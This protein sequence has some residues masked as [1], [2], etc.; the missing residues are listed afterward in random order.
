MSWP[1][2]RMAAH[3]IAFLNSAVD[4]PG[5]F[6]WLRGGA[7]P[8]LLV[9]QPAMID[10][11]FRN[12][13]RLRHPGSRSLAAVL[14]RRSLLWAEDP[15]HAAYRELLDP[16]LHGRRLD[17]YRGIVAEA[18]HTAV[19]ALRPG[20]VVELPG[21]TRQLTLR[22][23]ARILLGQADDAVLAAF[24]SWI[25]RALGARHRTLAYR[26]LMGGLPGSG[27][28]L[29]RMLVRSA[30]SHVDNQPRPLAALM[31]AGDGPLGG[32]DDAELRDAI[33]SLLFAGHETT[34]AATAWTLYWLD[35]IPSLRHDVRDELA[36]TAGSNA[37]RTPLLHAVIQETLR[38][39]PPVTVAE[40]RTLT[41]DA[42]IAGHRLPAGTTLSPSVY[43]AHHNPEQF[44]N[45]HRFDPNRFLGTRVP[46]RY[47]FP[48]GGGARHCVGSQLAHLEIRM[49]VAAVLGLRDWRCVNPRAGVPQPRGH[50]MAPASRLRM[51]V[52]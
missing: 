42:E 37:S 43:L 8:K 34:A 27:P 25:E 11:I 28:E 35:R 51:R 32:L 19:D 33:V 29:D 46:T 23:I 30:K 47:Y 26:W 10:W 48:F 5:G 12:D 45:P 15:R 14:G 36:G 49:I 44:P 50:A 1:E 20:T 4:T 52:L 22:I 24:T 13:Q 40:H 39:A 17:N 18:V 31:L 38:L 9:W 3:P 2:L 7:Q 41:T 6:L 16:A 21:W